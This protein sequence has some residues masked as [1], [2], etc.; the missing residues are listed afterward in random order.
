MALSNKLAE[1]EGAPVVAP[2]PAQNTKAAG[3]NTKTEQFKQDGANIRS[4]YTDDQKALEGSKSDKVAFVCALGDPNKK[5]ARVEGKQSIDSYAVVGYKFKALEDMTVPFAPIKEGFKSL[6]DVEPATEKAVKAGEVFALNLVETAQLIS[7]IEYA[8]KFC[9]ED[10]VVV[11]SVKASKSREELLPILSKQGTGSIKSNMELI[12]EMQGATA[13]S[14][15]TPVIKPEFAE[16]FSNLY[17]KKVAKRGTG[18]KDKKAGEG[19]ANIAAAF[20]NLYASK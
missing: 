7:R 10:D 18:T 19:Q 11:L 9:G 14:K 8:G 1:K 4:Q 20:R 13:D 3:A 6:T 17:V 5:Q 2:T 12:A 15:G 16:S